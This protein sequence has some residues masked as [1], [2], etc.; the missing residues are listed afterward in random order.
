MHTLLLAFLLAGLPMAAAA[1]APGAV[2]KPFQGEWNARLE[3]CGT[4]MNDSRLVIGETEVSYFES[5]GPVLAAVTQGPEL[6][7]I[8]ELSGEGETWMTTAQ[9]NLSPDGQ[10]LPDANRFAEAPMVRYRCPAKP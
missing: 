4:G 2:P 9:F 8:L 3:D 10:Q 1:E 6:A 5:G 7:L